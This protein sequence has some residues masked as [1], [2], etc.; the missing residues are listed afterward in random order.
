MWMFMKYIHYLYKI[1]ND[2]DECYYY[3]IH[4]TTNI[5]DMYMGS[6]LRLWK[7]YNK[8]GLHHFKKEI[9]EYFDTR[10]LALKREAEIVN[11][12]L[13]KDPLCYNIRLGGGNSA[14]SGIVWVQIKETKEWLSITTE[15]YNKNKHLYDTYSSN[16]VACKIKGT[17]E[18]IYIS[19]KEF[20]ENRD[21]YVYV[22][23]GRVVVKDINNN[24]FS[25]IKNDPRLLTGKLKY[26]HDGTKHK[27]STIT[28]MK[29]THAKNKHQQGEK[30]SRYGT[31]WIHKENESISIKKEELTKW[32][33]LGWTLGRKIKD[34]SNIAKANKDKIWIF[35]DGVVK[36]ISKSEAKIYKDSGWNYGRGSS[37][38][39]KGC[40]NLEFWNNL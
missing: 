15:E 8:H 27:E 17:N 18:Y 39:K 38:H 36:H 13:I 30:N 29:L 25:V 2:F 4:S 35:K 24:C 22:S 31:C 32:L 1:T 14:K 23:D 33:D 20:H 10:E 12:D 26:L 28:K 3:G 37:K 6:G 34:S 16:K 11:I 19:T 21:K 9:L 5:D 7:A 40:I